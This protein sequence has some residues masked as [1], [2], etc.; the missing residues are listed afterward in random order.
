[1]KLDGIVV[2]GHG[3]ASANSSDSRF[4]DGTLTLQLPV[5]SQLGLD[6]TGL[7]AGTINASF[8]MVVELP[9]ASHTFSGVRWHPDVPQEDFSFFAVDIEHADTIRQ[10]YV[11]RPH[12]ETKPEH[13]QRQDVLEL[14]TTRI[15]GLEYGDHI[16]I[17]FLDNPPIG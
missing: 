16:S 10:G 2:R 1:M 11:Y 6:L 3:V 5:F 7:H 15:S 17:R 13:H 12:P 14:I 9:P 4:P 8:G